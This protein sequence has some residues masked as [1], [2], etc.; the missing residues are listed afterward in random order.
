MNAEKKQALI[1]VIFSRRML[2]ALIMGFSCGLPLLLTKTILQAWMT[3]AGVDLTVI[4]LF[5]LVGIPYTVKFL[6]APVVDRF[7]MPFLG[8]RRGWL[9]VF[10]FSLLLS[11]VGLGFTQ[12]GESPLM[13]AFVAFLVTFF[14]ASQDIVVDAYRREDLADEELGLG[15]SLYVNGYLVAARLLVAGGGM[16]MADHMS[17][18]MLYV[19]MAAFMVPGIITTLLTPEPKMFGA[20]KNFTEAVIDPFREYFSRERA[21]WILAFILMYKLGDNMAAE[22]AT[23]FYLKI[24]FSKTEIG[25]VAK[26]FGFGATMAGTLTGGVIML[27]FGINRSL[28]L[29]G[30]LQAIST[31]FFALLAQV[32][33]SV[34]LLTGVIAFENLSS[35]M[36]TSAFVAFMASITNK[37]FTA[38]QY[39]LLTSLM[40]VPR[41]FASAPTGLMA[42]YMGWETFFVACALIAI[43][44]MLLL[45]KFAPWS[46]KTSES[47]GEPRG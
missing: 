29:F 27:R 2:V 44:G 25:T 36:G 18:K 21:I 39:A 6:W 16:I 10:Q 47:T 13:V 34:P 42:K 5:A 11:I 24:G 46:E 23:P 38:T 1:R 30:V 37:K 12:P 8:R 17:Y 20:P 3:E 35:G 4:G 9:I 33:Y 43:P 28:W 7:I 41:V 19:I 22:M 40:G 15:S 45:L 26:I 14:S 31:A 32:G